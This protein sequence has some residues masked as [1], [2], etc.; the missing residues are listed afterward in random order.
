[1][2]LEIGVALPASGDDIA[3]VG[4]AARHAEAAGFD[5]VWI[6]DHLADGRPLL[7]SV[8]ALSTAAAVTDRVRIGFGVLQLALRHPAWAAKQIGSLQFLS[9]NRVVLGVG[10]GGA[11]PGEWQ[12]AGV[13]LAE[14]GRRTDEA[15][16]ILPGLLGGETVTLPDGADLTLAPKVAVPPIWIGGSSDAALRRAAAY[17]DGW[18][19]SMVQ[20]DEFPAAGA[21]LDELAARQNRPAPALGTLAIAA[22]GTADAGTVAG[23]LSARLGIAADRAA[24]LAIAGNANEIADK[25]GEYIT[26]GVRQ[27]VLAP[28]GPGWQAQFDVFAEVRR[29]LKG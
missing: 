5:S 29:Q 23:F 12:A 9:G 27:F 26:A 20:P 7:D 14:R 24:P 3:D 8:V 16:R 1:M 18:L 2:G 19:A 10:A 13:P 17:G 6:G 4:T 22:A 28:F 21:R 15:L 25:L 11:I